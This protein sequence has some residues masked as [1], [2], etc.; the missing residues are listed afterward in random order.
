V[1][2]THPFH[3]LAGRQFTFAFRRHTWG[4]DRVFFLDGNGDLCGLPAGW[5]DVA[6]VD[7]FVAVAAGRSALRIA[8]VVALADLLD[9]LRGDDPSGA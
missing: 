6:P 3:P 2:V 9:G 7:P 8:D 1:K 5:T 4:E